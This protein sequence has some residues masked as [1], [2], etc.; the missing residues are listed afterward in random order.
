MK[1]TLSSYANGVSMPFASK[2]LS[3]MFNICVVFIFGLLIQSDV[4][5]QSITIGPSTTTTASVTWGPMNAGTTVNRYNRTAYIYPASLFADITDGDRILALAFKKAVTT[6]PAGTSNFKIY[7]KN[8]T[9]SAWPTTVTWA[10]EIANATLVFDGS[11]NTILG[12]TSGF[13][14]FPFTNGYTF[15][16]TNGNN[17][18]VIVEYIQTA[19]STAVTWI[20]DT[21]TNVPEYATG[22]TRYIA[23]TS[24]STPG[25]SLS[26]TSANHPQMRIDFKYSLN[27]S[28]SLVSPSGACAGTTD[29][30]RVRVNNLGTNALTN[31]T[32]NWE[33]N[34]V[35]QT[36]FVYTGNIPENQS[37]V[38]AI[39]SKTFPNGQ[40][41]NIKAWAHTLNGAADKFPADDTLDV[42]INGP[43]LTG[44]YT[45]GGV[46]ASYPDLISAVN[47]LNAR[48]VCSPVVFNVDAASGPY[49]GQLELKNIAGSSAV[50][51]ITFNGNGAIITD[52]ID[53]TKVSNKH[54][55]FLNGTDYTT[56]NNFTFNY[57][58]TSLY[59]LAIVIG[60]NANYN[61]IK[62]CKIN[63]DVNS[64]S[65]DFSAISF[66]NTSAGYLQATSASYNVIEDN[67]I[68][69]GQAGIVLAGTSGSQSL[70]KGNIIRNNTIYDHNL[71]GVYSTATDSTQIIG[72]D[73]SKPN[74]TVF[75]TSY[76][77]YITGHSQALTIAR[78]KIH[79]P[80][81][82]LLNS[83]ATFFG[84]NVTANDARAGKEVIIKNNV[85]YNIK[86][87]GIHYGLH[88]NNS[89]SIQY[90]YNTVHVD[91]PNATGGN[92][93]GMYSTGAATGVKYLNN[94]ISIAKG[95][96]GNKHGVWIN[97]ADVTAMFNYNNI[98]VDTNIGKTGQRNVG[99]VV[100]TPYI[101]LA[102]WKAANANMWDQNSISARSLFANA[103]NG[104]LTPNSFD[105][106]NTASPLANVT[107]D[108]N[109]N[110]RSATTPDPGAYEFTP[111]LND[112]GLIGSNLVN[113]TCSGTNNIA[114]RLK[115]FGANVVNTAQIN[116]SFNGV[117]QTS[118]NY[119]GAL[120]PGSD[121]LVIV[122][123]KVLGLDT[124]Y[125][126]QANASLPNGVV[127]N[128]FSNDTITVANY[129]AAMSGTYTVGG[130]GARYAS[131]T[132]A[133][134]DLNNRGVCGPVIISVNKNAGPYNEQIKINEIVGASAINTVS[135]KGHGSAL[136]FNS[137]NTNVRSGFYLDGAD[138]VSIDSFIITPFSSTVNFGWGIHLGNNSNFNKITNNTI[139]LNNYVTTQNFT[140]I[141]LTGSTSSLNTVGG[142]FVGNLIE[143]NIIYGGV[144]NINIYGVA[145]QN[146]LTRG[147]RIIGNKMYDPYHYSVSLYNQDSAEVSRNEMSRSTRVTSVN[148]VGV[149]CNG[150][151][152][153]TLVDGNNIHDA[154][155]ANVTTTNAPHGV[156]FTNCPHSAGREALVKNNVIYNFYGNGAH[157]GLYAG[158]T[159][160]YI[161]FYNNT[162]NLDN[163]TQTAGSA[164]GFYQTGTTTNIDVKNNIF[165]IA[166]GG[167]TAKYGI[168]LA[169]LPPGVTSNYNN[170]FVSGTGNNVG[171]YSSAQ[172]TLTAWKAVNS[173][174]YDQ[175][176]VSVDPE[177][178][179]VQT[180]NF[181]PNNPAINNIATPIAVVNN[182]Y[183]GA[184][185]SGTPDIGAIEFTPT[186]N[187]A[188]VMSVESPSQICLSTNTVSVK[189]KNNGTANLSSLT[190]N[191]SINNVMQTPFV[192]SGNLVRSDD[193]IL[194]IGTFTGVANTSYTIKVWSTLPNALADENALNDTVIKAGMKT[195][196]TGLYI[197]GNSPSDFTSIN[198]A[199]TDLNTR[200][201]CGPV[202]ISIKEADGP[203]EEKVSIATIPGVNATNTL[204]IKGNNAVLKSLIT[205]T[206]DRGVLTLN[207]AD[208]VTIDSLNVE[209]MDG[210]AY[211]YALVLT[212]SADNN[213]IKNSSFTTIDTS[214]SSFASVVIGAPG[215]IS[216]ASNSIYNTLDNNLISG[217]YY[218]L[219]IYGSS[220]NNALTR[221]NSIINNRIQDFYYYG[222]YHYYA[223][224]TQIIGNDISR[225]FATLMSSTTYATYIL[226]TSQNLT[227]ANN[228]IHN[229]FDQDPTGTG[230]LYGYHL[231]TGAAQTGKQT[232]VKN[233]VIY[234]IQTSGTIYGI[235]NSTSGNVAYYHNTV[236]LDYQNATAG[237]TYGFYQ[238]GSATGIELLNN[239]FVVSRSGTGVK[240]GIYMVTAATPLTTNYNN[241]YVP[242]GNVG[243]NSSART[244][245]AD[246]QLVNSFDAN[247]ISTNP[248]FPNRLFG[249]FSPASAAINNLGTPIPS[250][251]TDIKGVL[252]N[253]TNPDMGAYEFTPLSEDIAIT[254]FSLSNACVGT[255]PIVVRLRTLGSNT[256]TSANINWS[257]N[258]VAQTPFA[259][260]GS[261]ATGSDT[262]LNIGT[263]NFVVGNT[264]NFKF[265]TSL[266]NGTT[267][268]NNANDTLYANGRRTGLRGVYTIGGSGASYP[269]LT[270]AVNDLNSIGICGNVTF[271]VNPTA[272]PYNEQVAINNVAGTSDT[273]RIV[274]N[275]NGATVTFN[276]TVSG[277]RHIIKLRG[278]DYVTIDS[279]RLEMNPASTYG[280]PIH[281]L[282]GSNHNTIKR[283]FVR[284]VENSSSSNYGGIV[285]SGSETSATGAGSDM[286]F[287]TI[288]NNT[289]LNGYY[290]MMIYGTSASATN[291]KG[292]VIKNNK[293][294]DSYIYSLYTLGVDSTTI[295]GNEI[296]RSNRTTQSTFYGVY[297]TTNSHRTLVEK[298]KIHDPFPNLLTSTSA[299]YGIYTNGTDAL[300]GEFIVKNNLIYNVKSDGAQYGIANVS[301]DNIY[302]YNNTIVL[303]DQAPSTAVVNG[304]LQS[305]TTAA[306]G[307][308]LKNNNFFITRPGSA[309]RIGLYFT[310]AGSTFETDYN[311][312]YLANGTGVNAVAFFS[313]NYTTLADWKASNNNVYDQNSVET[314]PLFSQANVGNFRPFSGGL[315]N[316]GVPLVEVTTDIMDSLRSLT[317]PD[318]GA[319][320][321]TAV[322]EDAGISSLAFSTVCAGV[323]PID[324]NL[325]NSSANV[326]SSV[327]V[328]WTVNGIAQPNFNFV[329]ALNPLS[330]TV[331]NLGTYNFLQGQ[332]Y[333]LR[334]W[335]SQPNGL[336]DS[337]P[338]N[339]TLKINNFT[340]ALN[341]NYTIGGVGADFANLIAAAASLSTGGV[342]GPVVF[343]MNPA[344]GPYVGQV[345]FGNINGTSS[346]NTITINGNGS[347][348]NATISNTAK[349]GLIRLNG[350]DY[351][352]ID[353]IVANVNPG[354]VAG[355]ALLIG[356]NAN[357]NHIKNSTFKTT[358]TTSTSY[359]AI[360]FSGDEDVATTGSNSS[361]NII[362]KNKA[363]GGYYGISVY[364]TSGGNAITKGNI[365]K[366]NTV[367]DFY[368][369][370]I[371]N[372]YADSTTISGNDISRPTRNASTTTYGVYCS[373]AS[374]QILVEKNKIHNLFDQLPTNTSTMYGIGFATS[375]A[376]AGKFS[377]VRNNLIYNNGNNGTHYNL[378]NSTSGNVLYY[379]NTIAENSTSSTAG[380]SYGIY[381]TGSATGIEYKNNNISVTRTGSGVKYGIYMAT[382][383]SPITSNYNNFYVPNGSVGYNSSAQATLA[384]WKAVLSGAFDANS[385]SINP[386]FIFANLGN[387]TPASAG[388][389]NLGTSLPLVVDDIN[390]TLRDVNTPD[391]GAYEFT[392]FVNDL[393]VVEILYPTATNSCGLPNDS[394]VLTVM[395]TGTAM[396][397]GFNVKLDVTGVNNTSITYNYTGALASATLDT[398]V[399][400]PYN[401]DLSGSINLKVYTQLA[402]DVYRLNDTAKF[403]FVTSQASPMPI[404]ANAS[405]CKGSQATL[406]ASGSNNIYRWYDAPVG[407]NL[408]TKNDTLITPIINGTTKFY[409]SGTTGSSNSFSVG[410][411]NVNI[412]TNGNFTN[413]S[414]QYLEFDALSTFTLDSVSIYPNG[415]GNVE[416]RL[417]SSTGT[418]LQTR[419]V[420]VTTTQVMTR[421]PVGFVIQPGTAYRMDGGPGTTTGGLWR[422]S[423]GGVY[424]YTVPGIVSITGNSFSTTAY[425]YYYNWKVTGG[426][427]S[428]PSPRKEV[429]V[430]TST[431]IAGTG[432][433]QGSVFQGV[434]NAG[435]SVNP[436]RA[437]A[438]DTLEYAIATPTG[439]NL[440]GLG[441]T[442]NIVNATVKT[443]NNN[444]ANGTFALVGN[445]LRFIPSAADVDSN[446][447]LS[448]TVK[449]L[450]A[451]VCD[452]FIARQ[453]N[454]GKA[455]SVNLGSDSTI[456][457][458]QSI[459][460]DAGAGASYLWSTGATTQ[461]I[462]ASNSGTY[463]VTV[464]SISG[465]TSSDQMILTVAPEINTNL[466]ADT[467]ICAGS[468]ITLDAGAFVGASYSWNTGATT[469][470]IVAST[471]GVYFVEVS[472]GDCKAFDTIILGI[473]ALPV[474]DLGADVSICEGDSVILSAGNT[475]A[476]YLWST[477]ATTQSIIVK[478]AGNYSVTVT[479]AN[480]CV[481][482]DAVTISLKAITTAAFTGDPL[483]GLSWQFAATVAAGHTYLWNF[484]DPN[485][486]SNTSQLV[487]PLHT[488]SAPG[489][490][491]VSLTMVN[492][493]TGCAKTVSRTYLVSFIGVGT[494]RNV[495]TFYAA[496]NPFE[497]STQI[498]YELAQT[499]SV[500]LEVYDMLGRLV[501]TVLNEELQN[502]GRYQFTFDELANT[503][504]A[505][506]Y[507]VRLTVNGVSNVVRIVKAN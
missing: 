496:P 363:N 411:L 92:V 147:N 277:Q 169:T 479:N 403:S 351:L 425:Y 131:I 289:I 227:I 452:T 433:T 304:F 335:T 399:I 507:Q 145:G 84:I 288:E 47:D 253:S 211:G 210:S 504:A 461:S 283:N 74:R 377:V 162:V 68:N 56:I 98:Y 330:S 405:V 121:T 357:Y 214:S 276:A 240:Y 339:D 230:T 193:S 96:N 164:Y 256:L 46:G 191:W 21:Q 9:L 108:I 146:A 42:K 29:S 148:F 244:T 181:K 106:N 53:A 369:Y 115:N 242:N 439:F 243:Y 332:S 404:A 139:N 423:A 383:A 78:N 291:Q 247:S 354:S 160:S 225:P 223:D 457:F 70:M 237:S 114:F 213:I 75:V 450:S 238:T 27:A 387:Y 119:T 161:R 137:V 41:I 64:S 141:T 245:L 281:I 315:D 451:N 16:T 460:L 201:V 478:T 298:N 48:G 177:F 94:N 91:N 430:S 346:T 386:L 44:T 441:T 305:G 343:N 45:V 447:I 344:A 215:S 126:V 274:F 463:S 157:Y 361:F 20:Y 19:A 483:N 124:A 458:G 104:D 359:G 171:Y 134:N 4:K 417:L 395:N 31:F 175:N 280:F 413:P 183:F 241:I 410:P 317:T 408:L 424:P 88:T 490:Y 36:P 251:T 323:S 103:L 60:N 436:D 434:F 454:V 109:G 17:L 446:F 327:T 23:S 296:Y 266:P 469:Q 263:A 356:P 485:S 102:D 348:V 506:V 170:I 218:G 158:G 260:S 310:A 38:I 163:K 453:L 370:G 302:Y 347:I 93:G 224:S 51:T 202:T 97:T 105:V 80:H 1:N 79:D 152:G 220:A 431:P 128:R 422:N 337:N 206:G 270:S 204:T 187:D 150:V 393:T 32:I 54:L 130:V 319:Y 353:S 172:A 87:N 52:T 62:N 312:F 257:I 311:N 329:G 445:I 502:A 376:Q 123:S 320:E 239:N 113:G 273:S 421:I 372:I 37:R 76:G 341:G 143:N 11:P 111:I 258:G 149:Y 316:K 58:E 287:N 190:L 188:E 290:T 333:S 259:Y 367:K 414:V 360:V 118:H 322:G 318:I 3:W 25:T 12:N 209:V 465:C 443:I 419:T 95:G 226:G 313:S 328:S 378:Y 262:L 49:M 231:S 236:V 308:K 69:G 10:T 208:Y 196:M 306:L 285:L 462:V 391:I 107:D 371:Y 429:V 7:V 476:T 352:T 489:T 67:I 198:A 487:N 368:A 468:N 232:V 448:A 416:V 477:G 497:G 279:F 142:Y 39:G 321:F 272:G 355:Y 491:T 33:F 184:T 189:I 307:L 200:G 397:A 127:D 379:N 250:V 501:S 420:A 2:K 382:A 426:A 324:V 156:Y 217:G 484:G 418:V 249:D 71:Y 63:L 83:T 194:T 234:N 396:Q 140:G 28:T 334:F 472:L 24:T 300:A 99:F 442:W 331:I 499:A 174:A 90:L 467:S 55:L 293:I 129:K 336:A 57:E 269:N 373:G 498:I 374:Q 459:T 179:R 252:R 358:D 406:V 295:S 186:V 8:T 18:A 219:T 326:L 207:G 427:E 30:I 381:Q 135:F 500:K 432:L 15:N 77:I 144:Y 235:Y 492:V 294:I 89:D 345:E 350:T 212:N 309:N 428:C 400:K 390:A 59:C 267:D 122:G 66:S 471:A 86:S 473:N 385:V 125:N 132:D 165:V 438:N 138:Y 394:V 155:N 286:N 50:N 402:N 154:Y 297:N 437:C 116:W 466:V 35:A 435:T 233:N 482:T 412:G 153:S 178:L 303:N 221:A 505:G 503:N 365:V 407:G 197:V 228:K 180:N 282:S 61:T 342:C 261:L 100:S 166:K 216:T 314:N 5:A 222:I 495:N 464:T 72:N 278:A 380:A 13:K 389:D 65:V 136:N 246:W 384:D 415:P 192:F 340:T 409:V 325:Q 73:I 444:N 292:N 470:T 268:L 349:R 43:A 229:M 182:D 366:N 255:Y 151:S 110:P 185:R 112:V 40:A 299:F 199:I 474:V 203:Y 22:S 455:E 493:A 480:G 14:T 265:W 486:G 248:I 133:A 85:V 271:N 284:T 456:C 82:N 117:A 195:G 388:L 6:A 488:F 398:I 494:E 362:E 275:G 34:G 264:Y 475:G 81:A 168:Y 440:A 167:T 364:G 205:V 26:S 254:E 301:S 120:N 401:T 375:A 392:P 449:D 173:A 101:T 338:T 176:S 481:A 159:S